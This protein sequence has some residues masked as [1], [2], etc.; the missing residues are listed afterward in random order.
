MKIECQ[1][2]I[3]PCRPGRLV[4]KRSMQNSLLGEALPFKGI[5]QAE[6]VA[7]DLTGQGL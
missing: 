7:A 3:F 5:L 6:S 2:E 4:L 1:Y